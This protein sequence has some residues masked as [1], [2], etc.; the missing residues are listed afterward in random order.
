MRISIPL[1]IKNVMEK[2]K[3][4]SY[5]TYMVGGA[6]RDWIIG[7]PCDDYDLCTDMPLEEVKEYFPDF[8]IMKENNHR[9]TGILRVGQQEIEISSIRGNNL[10]E[11]LSQRDFTMNAIACDE[12][13]NIIDY[14]GGIGDILRG[15]I[16]LVD[17]TGK[18][19]EIDPIRILRSLRFRGTLHYDLDAETKEVIRQKRSLLQQAS[20]E[21]VFK[22]LFRILGSRDAASIIRDNIDVFIE[23]IPE[24]KEMVNFDQKNDY[25]I[26]DVLEHTLQVIEHTPNDPVLRMAALFHDIGK[27][28]TFT[29]DENG[30][31]HFYGHEI[32]SC[33]IFL[34]FAEKY[35]VDKNTAEIVQKLIMNHDR[36]LS[37]KRSKA[38]RFMMGYG[39][40]DLPRL[41]QLREADIKAQNPQYI[42]RLEELSRIKK[43][44]EDMISQ[45]NPCLSVKDLKING[46][47]LM[48]MG[49]YDKKI[50]FILRDILE[51][52][53]DEIIQ[54]EQSEIVDYVSQHYL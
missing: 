21:R 37:T 19:L 49:F 16:S 1:T 52:V 23:I 20:P 43:R 9:N 6:I 3:A 41:F 29:E 54:N 15:K 40:N 24:I 27:P 44:Y 13:G 38:I 11:D 18:G 2:M 5:H 34:N 28:R 50:G 48:E 8:T 39:T 25:H 26:Y 35:H 14:Y 53:T 22:E 33:R 4:H 42:D 32:E 47:L 46:R 45:E 30:V 7:R 12:E 10:Q 36:E 51:K 31:G 17:K